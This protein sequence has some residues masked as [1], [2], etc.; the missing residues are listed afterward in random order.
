MTGYKVSLHSKWAQTNLE[1]PLRYWAHFCFRYRFSTGEWFIFLNGEMTNHGSLPVMRRTVVGKGAYII[2]QEQ[3]AFGGG[4]QRDQSYSGEI[5]Q[6]NIW[7]GIIDRV[8][9]QLLMAYKG[10]VVPNSQPS[11]V[12]SVLNGKREFGNMEG[13]LSMQ[14]SVVIE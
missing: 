10:W 8:V 5:T 1:T 11:Q 3:D 9:Q 2:G 6:L 4:F 13:R 7:T 14:L 12:D